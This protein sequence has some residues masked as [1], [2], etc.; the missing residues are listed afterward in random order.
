MDGQSVVRSDYHKEESKGRRRKEKGKLQTGR[1]AAG[2][3]EKNKI[4]GLKKMYGSSGGCNERPVGAAGDDR[5]ATFG[6]RSHE[7]A[8][9]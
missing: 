5:Q 1:E 2:K 9:I 7:R 8:Y 6:R 3:K 4:S